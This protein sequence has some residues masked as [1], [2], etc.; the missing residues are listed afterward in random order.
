M[1]NHKGTDVINTDRLI[2]RKF[3]LDDAK[4]MYKNWSSDS[5]VTKFLSWCC[6]PDVDFTKAL[7]TI[8]VSEYLHEEKYHWAIELKECGEVIGDIAIFNLKE[9]HESCEVGYCLSKNYWNKGIMGEALSS[10]IDYLF[11]NIGFNRI[12]AMHNADNVASGK[13]M[14]KNNMK[15]EG[16]LREANKLK[17]SNRFYDLNIYSILK[18]EYIKL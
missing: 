8:W 17:D 18:S 5:E 15:Y 7:I 2:L 3:K 16:T 11:R 4:D 1:L 6:H 12:V 13:V 10:V 14:I 9:K